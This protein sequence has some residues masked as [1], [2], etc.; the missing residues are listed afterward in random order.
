MET[1]GKIMVLL[2]AVSIGLSFYIGISK[3]KIDVHEKKKIEFVQAEVGM[4]S[5][6][7]FAVFATTITNALMW[8]ILCVISLLSASSIFFRLIFFTIPN[9]DDGNDDDDDDNDGGHIEDLPNKE[10][11]I[12]VP[13]PTR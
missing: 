10:A 7:A 6:I 5:S 2:F 1:A 8:W 3:N 4:M 13:E 11:K 12:I 9:N